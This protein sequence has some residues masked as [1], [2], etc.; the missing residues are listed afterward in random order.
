MEETHQWVHEILRRQG[1]TDSRKRK[2]IMNLN[3][4]TGWDAEID[5]NM[6]EDILKNKWFKVLKKE[7]I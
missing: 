2:M 5:A 3:S 4:T 7:G 6:V 1:Y